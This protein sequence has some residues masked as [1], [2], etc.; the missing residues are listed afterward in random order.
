MNN[1]LSNWFSRL[2]SPA[3]TLSDE[4]SDQI[5]LQLRATINR[6]LDRIEADHKAALAQAKLSY[7]QS[8]DLT[9]HKIL[10]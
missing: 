5:E 9:D 10:G 6:N 1:S 3:P 4:L 8:I 2:T 7:L